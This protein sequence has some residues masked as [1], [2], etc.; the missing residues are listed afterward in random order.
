M[1][2]SKSTCILWAHTGIVIVIVIIIITA[3]VLYETLNTI[4]VHLPLASNHVETILR[5][6]DV[7]MCRRVSNQ[8]SWS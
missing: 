4:N 8:S 7:Y 3:R 2:C 5:Q 1:H 6:D